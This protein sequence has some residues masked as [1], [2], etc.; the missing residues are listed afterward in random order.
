VTQTVVQGRKAALRPWAA[1]IFS[2]GGASVL[3]DIVGYVT[4]L[5]QPGSA[6][7]PTVERGKHIY[8]AICVACHGPGGKGN[9]LL[10][11]PD[12]TDAVWLYGGTRAAITE[13]IAN[14]RNGVM[15]AHAPLLGETRAR[16]AA[17]Y[18]WSLSQP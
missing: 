9:A 13:S 10:G 8:D 15:P 14:G 6:D 5:S 11:A 12:L 3:Y 4:S 2:M 16:L 18:V 1:S 7:A 17:A